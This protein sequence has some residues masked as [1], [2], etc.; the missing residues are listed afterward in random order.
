MI[1]QWTCE[2]RCT[3]CS[4]PCSCAHSGCWFVSQTGSSRG[5]VG[6]ILLQKESGVCPLLLSVLVLSV[7]HRKWTGGAEAGMTFWK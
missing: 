2:P 3:C 4:A 5:L 1:N 7:Q 6:R